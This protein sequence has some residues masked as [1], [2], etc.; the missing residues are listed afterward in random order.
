MEERWSLDC[1]CSTSFWQTKFMGV[2]LKYSLFL[3]GFVWLFTFMNLFLGQIHWRDLKASTQLLLQDI[4]LGVVLMGRKLGS[5]FGKVGT[6]EDAMLYLKGGVIYNWCKCRLP[7]SF[8]TAAHW[9]FS[10]YK[11]KVFRFAMDARGI[12]EAAV[13]R[14]THRVWLSWRHGT[15]TAHGL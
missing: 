13:R 3:C 5:P 4:F 14:R 9:R 7:S 10:F 6:L 11:K 1:F 15:P 8:V 2:L 12:G